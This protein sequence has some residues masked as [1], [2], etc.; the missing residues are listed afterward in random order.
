MKGPEASSSV[1]VIAGDAT[2]SDK[3][4]IGWTYEE[5]GKIYIFLSF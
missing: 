4:Q 5:N 2:S 3:H 1:N